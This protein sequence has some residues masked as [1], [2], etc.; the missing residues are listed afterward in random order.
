M[1]T[2][3]ST[4]LRQTSRLVSTTRPLSFPSPSSLATPVLL[5]LN[6]WPIWIRQPKQIEGSV[7]PMVIGQS[8]P[9]RLDLNMNKGAKKLLNSLCDLL[10]NN[11][12]PCDGGTAFLKHPRPS[13]LN[14]HPKPLQS[15]ISVP[16]VILIIKPRLIDPQWQ[17]LCTKKLLNKIMRALMPRQGL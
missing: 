16:R 2:I 11:V 1:P 9:Y 5:E 10:I 8:S 7:T 15:T 17:D 14:V 12:N 4:L 13:L 6:L 3:T